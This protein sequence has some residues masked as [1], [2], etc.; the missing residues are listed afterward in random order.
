V[1]IIIII[2]GHESLSLLDLVYLYVLKG[3]IVLRYEYNHMSVIVP[4]PDVSY[5][6]SMNNLYF[7]IL[8]WIV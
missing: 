3:Q 2:T 8:W 5:T 4:F 7:G 6:V 1:I